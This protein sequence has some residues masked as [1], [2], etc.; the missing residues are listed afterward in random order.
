MW[1]DFYKWFVSEC[2]AREL[3]F[4]SYDKAIEELENGE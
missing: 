4:T 1:V 2:E 3:E